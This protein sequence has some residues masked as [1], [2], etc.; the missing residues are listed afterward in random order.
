MTS[1]SLATRRSCSTAYRRAWGRTRGKPLFIR[2]RSVSEGCTSAL[3]HAAGSDC[4]VS[5]SL[6]LARQLAQIIQRFVDSTDDRSGH[7]TGDVALAQQEQILEI[8]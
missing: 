3:A 6:I 2:A 4:R 1:G 5:L 7:S 8:G